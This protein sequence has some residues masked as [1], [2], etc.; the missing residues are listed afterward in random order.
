MK[1][2]SPEDQV[3]TGRKQPQLGM[4]LIEI[5]VTVV[6]TTIV[7]LFIYAFVRN[8]LGQM[9]RQKTVERLQA[10]VRE[11]TKSIDKYLVSSGVGGDSLFYDPHRLLS[12][13]LIDGGHRVFEL[14]RDSLILTA[15]G[16]Y[17]GQV[18]N[19]AEPMTDKAARAFK[20][21]KAAALRGFAYV[22]VTAGS[23]QEVAQV[24]R[25]DADGTV[26]LTHDTFVP[27]PK[28][29]LVF[30]LERIRISVL[31]R[32][33]LLVSRESAQGKAGFVRDFLPTAKLA[34][35]DTVNFKV[36]TL[37]RLGGRIGYSLRFATKTKG[38]KPLVLE[39]KA[40]QTVLVRGY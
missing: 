26:R 3:A 40:S 10:S 4:T 27:Y 13:P 31:N 34:V 30:P 7:S 33:H 16:N 37:D 36:T 19:I 11:A 22:Y 35:G 14:S 25:V 1:F 39:R 18:A 28:G 20:V 12:A 38:R 6:V 21:D 23:A 24:A 29:T 17:T 9:E 8:W 5:M 2:H 15:Y 32:N